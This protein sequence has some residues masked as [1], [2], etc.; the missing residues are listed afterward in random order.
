MASKFISSARSLPKTLA[1]YIQ[2]LISHL[3]LVLLKA[4]LDSMAK[5]KL[6]TPYVTPN[7]HSTSAVPTVFLISVNGSSILSF[8]QAKNFGVILDLFLS[9]LSVIPPVNLVCLKYLQNMTAIQHLTNIL[10]VHAS[11]S[12]DYCDHFLVI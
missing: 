7:P 8:A 4:T 5:T 9:H 11:V 1:L 2:L 12:R 3:T 10:S 6:Q